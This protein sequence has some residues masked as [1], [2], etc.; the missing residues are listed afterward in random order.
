MI[1]FTVNGKKVE[2]ENPVS[3][4]RYIEAVG[5]NPKAVVVELNYTIPDKQQWDEIFIHE[6]DNLEIIKFIGGG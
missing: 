4:S 1:I 5:L 6:G 2:V 3:I